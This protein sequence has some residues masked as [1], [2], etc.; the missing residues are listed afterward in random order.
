MK[1]KG[2]KTAIASVVGM[3]F[4]LTLSILLTA[5]FSAIYSSYSEYNSAVNAADQIILQRNQERLQ[6]SM[7]AN[8]KIGVSSY[9]GG[10]S[11]ID[12]VVNVNNGQVYSS[13]ASLPLGVP[14]AGQTTINLNGCGVGNGQS[15]LIITSLGNS[16]IVS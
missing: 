15:L 9:W 13:C 7:Q 12:Y 11:L 4:I 3:L 16:F 5:Y 2:R 10:S 1:R 14:A 6:A 8:E